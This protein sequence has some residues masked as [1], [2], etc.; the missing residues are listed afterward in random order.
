MQRVPQAWDPYGER[1]ELVVGV[2]PG[3]GPEV[4]LIVDDVRA[5]ETVERTADAGENGLDQGVLLRGS[6]SDEQGS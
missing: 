4:A 1:G 5:D 3:V 2:G 6:R